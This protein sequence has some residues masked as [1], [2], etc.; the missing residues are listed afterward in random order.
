MTKKKHS[1]TINITWDM[2]ERLVALCEHLGTNPNSYIVNEIGKCVSR[3]ELI[4]QT[5][6]KPTDM[7]VKND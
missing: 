6:K 5:L 1:R 4:F 7:D 2:H 3:D